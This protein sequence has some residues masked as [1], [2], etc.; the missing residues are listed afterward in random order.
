MATPTLNMPRL[1]LTKQAKVLLAIAGLLLVAAPAAPFLW[2]AATDPKP[3]ELIET[4]MP[5]DDD[6]WPSYMVLS[7]VT[8]DLGEGVY[9]TRPG[10]VSPL[11]PRVVYFCNP[12]SAR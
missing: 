4:S 11:Q 2:K 12:G 3:A 10:L 7:G 1:R 9:V 6:Y 5:C 8:T